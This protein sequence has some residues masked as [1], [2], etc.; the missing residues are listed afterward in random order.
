MLNRL[1]VKAAPS[2][3][4]LARKLGIDLATIQA[5]DPRPILLEDS[6]ARLRQPPGRAAAIRRPTSTSKPDFGTPGTRIKLAGLR[7]EIAEHMVHAKQ[8]IPHYSYVE[9]CDVTDLVKL[10][11]SLES[12]S[13]ARR[14]ADLS[15][16]LR[17]GGRRR[18]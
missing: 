1:P 14:Q 11:D 9:E 4:C 2:V 18:P 15:G 8:T 7:R 3:R 5:A 17:Q 10:R 12:R 13:P 6:A 16:V